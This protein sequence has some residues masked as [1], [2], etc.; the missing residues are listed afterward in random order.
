MAGGT[1]WKLTA[2]GSGAERGIKGVG[3]EFGKLGDRMDGTR[4]RGEKFVQVS[5]GINQA[6]EV[7]QKIIQAVN[8]AYDATIGKLTEIVREQAEFADDLAKTSR[9]LGTTTE[10][11]QSW[12]LAAT[13]AGIEN[14]TLDKSILR[15]NKTLV[16]ADRGLSTAIDLL[17][18]LGIQ[19]HDSQGELK[20]GTDVLLEMADAFEQELIPSQQQAAITSQLLGDRTGYMASLL[21]DGRDAIAEAHNELE[22]YGAY[23]SDELLYVSEEF[24][25]SIDRMDVATMGLRNTLSISFTPVLTAFN[26]SMAE[27]IGTSGG[28]RAMLSSV[29]PVIDE[30]AVVIYGFIQAIMHL[31]QIVEVTI[32]GVATAVLLTLQGVTDKIAGMFDA[33]GIDY[34]AGVFGR[35]SDALGAP[36]ERML[37]ILAETVAELQEIGD[38]VE[39]FKARLADLRAGGVPVGAGAAAAG[40]PTPAEVAEGTAGAGGSGEIVVPL[41]YAGIIEAQDAAIE[42]AQ[43]LEVAWNDVG[44]SVQGVIG[45]VASLTRGEQSAGQVVLGLAQTILGVIGQVGGP[46]AGV[47]AGAGSG[48]L[49]ILSGA[50]GDKGLMPT[51]TLADSGAGVVPGGGGHSLV[52]RRN[53]E[54]VMDPEGT[55]SITRIV[56]MVEDM[57]AGNHGGQPFDGYA[58]GGGLARVQVDGTVNMDG[59]TVGRLTMDRIVDMTRA[60]RGGLS[61]GALEAG[62]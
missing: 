37:G 31:P 50:L 62:R 28:W 14:R 19:A 38:N 45:F 44:S 55:G 49:G 23:M 29:I 11:L 41:A 13:Y 25:D 26:E 52:M 8:T 34:L 48:I 46:A 1:H 7:G 47:V 39:A 57:I 35:A 53:D 58:A 2:D 51:L 17:G 60:G 59:R 3:G 5:L 15:M 33:I 61:G 10:Q 4:I 36:A 9:A 18:R 42:G 21:R 43:E 16:D 20:D 22:R 40:A 56:R 6:L 12:R 27:S 54:V 32:E 30:L 24:N